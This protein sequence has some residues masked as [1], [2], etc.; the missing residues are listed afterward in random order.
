MNVRQVSRGTRRCRVWAAAMVVVAG[1]AIAPA[2]LAARKGSVPQYPVG[3]TMGSPTGALP[4]AGFY[5][6]WKPNYATADTVD[7]NGNE[8]GATSTTWASNAQILWVPGF[9]LLGGTYAAFIRNIGEVNVTIKTPT[10][11]YVSAAALPDTEIVPV[12]LSW[13]LADHLFFDAELGI[14]LD[15]GDYRN[16]PRRINIGQKERTYEPNVSLTYMDDNWLFSIH[17]LFDINNWNND[18]GIID[19]RTVSYRNGT[20]FDM[21]WT[22]FHRSGAWNYGL[23]G[24]FLRQI[25]ADKGPAQL[26]GGRPWEYAAGIGGSYRFGRVSLTASYTHDYLARNVGKK[27][28]LLVVLSV[29]AL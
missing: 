18:A 3:M 11:Q 5:V 9:K 27:D 19:G 7:N 8:T 12:N 17:P 24:Y 20:T 13:K 6:I 28:M 22:A 21:D 1:L 15:D 10:G 25:T 26:N 4:P 2:A 16:V 29:H 23:V 14:Y